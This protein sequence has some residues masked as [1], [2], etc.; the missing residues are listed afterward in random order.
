MTRSIQTVLLASAA[1]LTS[2]LHGLGV[3]EAQE[4]TP[5]IQSASALD[6]TKVEMPFVIPLFLENDKFTSALVLVNGISKNNYAD[7]VVR[8]LSGNEVIKKRVSFTPHSRQKI[9][10][11]DLLSS[12]ESPITAGSIAILQNSSLTLRRFRILQG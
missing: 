8:S 4:S 3:A 7:V 1:M 2:A 5:L 11:A 9:E 12:A 10:I 6:T